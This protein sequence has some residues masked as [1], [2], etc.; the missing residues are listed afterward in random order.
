VF[1][2]IFYEAK[3]VSTHTAPLPPS[4][5]CVHNQEQSQLGEKKRQMERCER[6]SGVAAPP[7]C[8]RSEYFA[9]LFARV[10]FPHN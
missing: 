7:L 4:E 1:V 6:G 5:L 10:N 3:A 2:Y 9:A 8:A